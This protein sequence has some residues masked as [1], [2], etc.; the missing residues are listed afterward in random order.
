MIFNEKRKKLTPGQFDQ[1]V[2]RLV[3]WVKGSVSPFTGDTKAKQEARVRRAREDQDF[4]NRTYLPHYFNQ[5]SP[6]FHG[7]MESLLA[8]G[9]AQQRP[10]IVAAPRG[11]AKSTRVTFGHTAREMLYKL[12][13]FTL[14]ISDTE[15]QAKGLTVSIRVEMEHNPRIVHDF[16]AQKT[17][18]WAA[19]DFVAKGGAR[20][21]A[22]GDGQGVRGLKH[23]PHRPDRAKVDDIESDE[24]VRNPERIK[25]TLAWIME[26]VVPSLDP[27]RGVLFVVGTLLSKRSVLAKLIANPAVLSKIYRA[28]EEPVWDDERKEFISGS[29]LWPERFPLERLS[30]IRNLIGSISFNKEYQNDPRDDEGLFQEQWIESHRYK[31]DSI[32]SGP[33]YTYQGI[34]PSLKQ[35]QSNDFKANVSA[36]RG[37]KKIYCRHAWI[38]KC[39]IDQMV[40]SAYVLQ[41]R[42]SALQVGLETEGWQVLL[43]REF[44]REAE[45]QGR[46]LP[47]VPIERKGVSKED[48]TR[49]GGLSPL[50]ENGILVFPHGPDSEVGDMEMLIEQLIYFPSTTVHDDGPDGL[51]IAVHLAEK[52]AMSKPSYEQVA[53]REARFGAG[54]W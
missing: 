19:G 25:Q 39:S 48:E 14:I 40:K 46:Y 8:E 51:E 16:G 27:A 23:G 47:I 35:G 31:W 38:K 6:P 4:F 3:E 28:I 37:E 44:D 34:D 53:Q 7:E 30:K 41:S 24:S 29:P 54:A 21:M 50:I 32:P 20:V 2:E 17:G 9:Q 18:Q 10:V 13:N 11:H 36:S 33:L 49:I 43:R 52:R 45:R 5:Q 15:T 22:R 26:A 1:E 12:T 42:F